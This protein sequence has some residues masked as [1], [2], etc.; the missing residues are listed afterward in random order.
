MPDEHHDRFVV[1]FE[2]EH[3]HPAYGHPA[4]AADAEWVH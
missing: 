2:V 3:R 4:R 1:T